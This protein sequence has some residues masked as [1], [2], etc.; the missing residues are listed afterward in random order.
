[1]EVQAYV[2]AYVQ[3][4][5]GNRIWSSKPQPVTFLTHNLTRNHTCSAG[6][7][8]DGRPRERPW[9]DWMGGSTSSLAH[10]D[11]AEDAIPGCRSVEMSHARTARPQATI[12]SDKPITGLPDSRSPE[13]S[14]WL[15]ILGQKQLRH[16]QH[17]TRVSKNGFLDWRERQ[18]GVW[19]VNMRWVA[20]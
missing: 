15:V 12:F 13:L 20:R 14:Q 3:G 2:Q 4:E 16:L 19:H 5:T 8:F 9:T 6:P 11:V 1:V 18:R 17:L 10:R 7:V